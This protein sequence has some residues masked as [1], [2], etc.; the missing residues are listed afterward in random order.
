MSRLSELGHGL[1]Q[2]KISIDFVGRKWLWYA[3]SGL[4]VLVAVLGLT[5]RGLNPGIEFVGGVQYKVSMPANEADNAHVVQIRDA[6]ASSG[7]PGT[8]SP[9][10]NT[11]GAHNILVQTKPLKNDPAD[12]LATIIRKAAGVSPKDISQDSIGA[13]WG[14]QVLNR[15]ITG[16]IVFL[17][18]VMI[19]IWAY[20]REW[21]MS[22]GAI[23]ALAHDL[24][25]T[26]GVYALSGFEVTPAT[27]T[28]VLTI[29]GFSLY[30]TVVVFDKVRENTKNLAR[31][32]QTYGEAANLAVNQTLVRSINTSVVALLPVG[33]LLYVGAVSL[34]SGDLKDLALAL[35]VGMAAG[36][37]SSIFI[38]TPLVVQLKERES[39]VKAGDARARRHR[40]RKSA[41]PYAT[42]PAYTDDMPMYD[43]PGARAVRR[44]ERGAETQ[45]EPEEE[46]ERAVAARGAGR[47][48]RYTAGERPASKPVSRSAS[49]KRAQPSRK[50]RSQR[51]K[52]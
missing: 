30:D 24:V 50:P 4:I 44:N 13:T 6:V 26:V 12:K 1:Y 31:T 36:A 18:L 47:P 11:S 20:F 14:S 45:P 49:S 38:A 21:K 29:L 51:G 41:D 7:I 34:G 37:Y 8:Q 48:G 35:F 39:G 16:L 33:A 25:I 32:R 15:A 42:V 3:I 43:E 22:V 9:V 40:S 46:A 27:V 23:V 17:V 19:F 5:T 2:G 28:G 52:K 10:V